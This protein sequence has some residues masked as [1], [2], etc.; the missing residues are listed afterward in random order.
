[1]K[2]IGDR[3]I[4]AVDDA[5]YIHLCIP[6][7]KSVV[8]GEVT[9]VSVPNTLD[10]MSVMR[11]F[12]LDAPAP[13]D[14][15][16]F[17]G[18][19][20]PYDHQRATMRFLVENMRAYNLSGMGTGKTAATAWAADYLMTEGVIRR[21]LISAPLSCLER[22]WGDALFQ[23]FPHRKFVVLHGTR[24]QRLNAM[25]TDWDFAVVNHHGIGII[26][27]ELPDD[28]DLIIFDE[29]AAF[30]NAKSKTLWGEAKKII[31]PKRW[32]WG[33]TGSPTPNAPTDAWAQSKLL[34]P[35]RYNGSFTRFKMDSM[36]QLGQFKWIPRQRS[37]Q[38]V[39]QVLQPS[40]RYA[41]EDC[42]DLP[43]TILQNREAEMSAEQ[44]Q[45]YEK[46]R[47]ECV[48]EIQGVQ[49]TA[50]NA[51]VLMSK[52]VQAACGCIIGNGETAELDFGPRLGVLEEVIEEAGGKVIIF[53]PFTGVI[54]ALERKLKKK[55]TCA[56]V[57]GSTSSGKRNQI[58]TDFQTK[59]DPQLLIASAGCMAHGLT[60]TAAA[61][62]CWFAPIT[63]HDYYCQA[64][65]RIVRPGQTKVTNIVHISASPVEKRVY[66]V[67]Q[68]KG[69]FQD[70]V[71]DLIKQK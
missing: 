22:V 37:E 26:G 23:M 35:E 33:L 65:A 24:Q 4:F 70:C 43:E 58:F 55:Y 2:I 64:N 50:V 60:L 8:H 66:Q 63:S 49:I 52:L 59:A 67:L 7:A 21:C 56:V 38:L 69:K 28:V 6:E 42:I 12:G 32:V 39:D 19:F 62:I 44:K 9:Y 18:R 17:P 13:I 45:H 1:M 5:E 15:Y 48:T 36:L 68:D 3:A 30:R 20:A 41:L 29:L 25:E 40:I 14:G 10:A 31:T 27:E 54:A 57:E 16:T 51:A 34:T 47:K 71:L 46:L 11:S 53:V 61:T